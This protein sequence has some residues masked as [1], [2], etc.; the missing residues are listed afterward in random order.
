MPVMQ[1]SVKLAPFAILFAIV[2]SILICLS[3]SLGPIDDRLFLLPFNIFYCWLNGRFYILDGIEQLSLNHYLGVSPLVFYL[4]NAI[5]FLLLF[6]VLFRIT[7]KTFTNTTSKMPYL[8]PIVASFTPGLC[9]AYFRL[10]VPE[11][12]LVLCLS[13]LVLLDLEGLNDRF[14]KVGYFLIS[15]VAFLLKEPAFLII[16][17]L[18]FF[19]Y[20][21]KKN[22]KFHLLMMVTCLIYGVTLYFLIKLKPA[23][24]NSYGSIYAR[25]TFLF[26]KNIF[27]FSLNDPG[28]V[29]FCI[30]VW[31][32]LLIKK[33][34]L[35]PYLTL[36]AGYF[37]IFLVLGLYQEYYLLPL[38]PFVIVSAGRH[39]KIVPRLGQVVLIAF[40]FNS[41]LAGVA[42][43]STYKNEPRGFSQI[44]HTLTFKPM[45]ADNRVCY[46]GLNEKYSQ[47]ILS[48][49]SA[50]FTYLKSS[51]PTPI[52][53]SAN[54][55]EEMNQCTYLINSPYNF[56][57]ATIPSNW[58][59]IDQF[60][61]WIS[62]PNL[63]FRS[64]VKYFSILLGKSNITDKNIFKSSQFVLFSKD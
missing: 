41:L 50:F 3:P 18:S 5:E 26:L 49:S 42:Q 47:E 28:I 35:D 17:G 1:K 33:K 44:I 4:V 20:F 10:L 40:I 36:I 16:G 46:A 52:F 6:F 23:G 54:T 34:T 62:I 51:S 45:K 30:P 63:S 14:K 32:L 53:T 57:G 13:V 7:K 31:F 11:R 43:I 29:F 48:A 58:K 9:T 21:K 64:W 25:N 8:V 22:R 38:L 39:W 12:L 56:E 37:S 60:K 27:N 59:L 24:G 19:N 55:P 2:F 15:I 61:P